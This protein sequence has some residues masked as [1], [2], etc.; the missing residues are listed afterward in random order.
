MITNTFMPNSLVSQKDF[1]IIANFIK[2]YNGHCIDENQNSL[3]LNRLLPLVE[4]YDLN[5]LSQLV[6]RLK[7]SQFEELHKDVAEKLA[8][9]ETFFFR[10]RKPFEKIKTHYLET[11]INKSNKT[12]FNIWCAAC[13]TG[14]EAYSIAIMCH[15]LKNKYKH[16]NLTFKINATDFSDSVLEK[17]KAGYYSQFDIQR[18]LTINE[19]IEYF[20]KV[21]DNWIVKDFLKNLIKFEKLNLLESFD[22]LHSYDLILCRNVLIY[23]DKLQKKEI[24]EKIVSLMG[25]DSVLFLGVSETVVGI[26]VPLKYNESMV[27]YSKI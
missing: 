20:D 19:T 3:I 13:S 14:Q 16:K 6:Q 26:D 15:E 2:K 1:K 17:A 12:N 18:G 7:F 11:I 8:I 21:N 10:D 4:K 5:N 22:D 24:L 25:E 27:C 23:F 9:H